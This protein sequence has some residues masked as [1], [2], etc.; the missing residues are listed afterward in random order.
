MAGERASGVSMNDAMPIVEEP[1]TPAAR[2]FAPPGFAARLSS[3]RVF[4]LPPH[5]LG[6][7]APLVALGWQR[8]WARTSG[9][10]L[11]WAHAAVLF[12]AVWA[13]YLADRLADAARP[14]RA[15]T[16]TARHRFSRR[17]RGPLLVLLGTVLATLAVLAPAAL[18]AA[19]FRAGLGLLAVQA[20]YFALIHARRHGS[21]RGGE[22]GPWKEGWV[23]VS[24]AAGCAL[25][26]WRGAAEAPG[27]GWWA[28]LGCFAVLCFLNC[29]LITRWE[30]G[31]SSR[32]A[33]SGLGT[34][35]V[36]LAAGAVLLSVPV[37]AGAAGLWLLDRAG[38]RLRPETRRVLADVVLLSPWL[39]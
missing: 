9:A 6:L 3:F 19:D 27:A 22:G 38:G 11:T 36:A 14:E 25:F 17:W 37:A 1:P 12:G 20:S 2:T 29:A 24:F 8:W 10:T 23:G 30:L 13:I 28:A 18:P 31:V 32:T 4:L 7:D 5:L 34:A 15:D 16:A 26:P 39:F 35:C 33:G 21:G